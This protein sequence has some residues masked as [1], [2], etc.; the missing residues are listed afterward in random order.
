MQGVSSWRSAVGSRST[1]MSEHR[2]L[3][4]GLLL[5]EVLV[6]CGEQSQTGSQPVGDQLMPLILY[7][8]HSHMTA[9]TNSQTQGSIS[10]EL[11]FI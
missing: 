11:A 10:S 5:E 9:F 8:H 6:Y 2:V 3:L 7:V 4:K 1:G